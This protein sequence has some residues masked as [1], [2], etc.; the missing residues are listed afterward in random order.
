VEQTEQAGVELTADK[1]W[2]I[3]D[4]T[5]D[6]LTRAS[7]FFASG[8]YRFQPP[9]DLNY[10][11]SPTALLF[12]GADYS[13]NSVRMLDAPRK[14]RFEFTTLSAAPSLYALVEP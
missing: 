9:Q 2:Y 11:P 13:F 7:G 6:G 10:G 12:M 4:A 5:S 3:L 14:M 1:Q 8:T